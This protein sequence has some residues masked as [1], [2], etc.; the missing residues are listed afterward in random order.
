VQE[1]TI[2]IV[3]VPTSLSGG[4]YQLL[5]GGTRDDTHEK[6]PFTKGVRAPALVVLDPDLTTT[7]PEWVWLST[8]IRGVDHCVE[9]MC[10]L[11]S[12]PEAD[13]SAAEGL[14]LLVPGLLE[15]KH[16]HGDLKARLQCQMG[17]IQAM[18]AVRNGVPM[19]ASH[20]I[21]HQLGPLGMGHGETSCIL[22]PTVCKFNTS[23]NGERQKKVQDILWADEEVEK[24]LKTRGLSKEQADLGDM[25]DAIIRELGMP[26]T[27]KEKG[28]GREKLE[29]LA[30][31][32][33]GDFWIKTNPIP[34]DKESQVMEILEQVVG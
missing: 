18:E 24:V 34:I 12:N 10:S 33:L 11:K 23:V 6:F 16:N 22:L 1:V 4:E 3:C 26:R 20:A 32:S 31:N 2:P 7:T 15:T 19:G 29:K 13:A 27:L 25:L 8:G 14:K 30:K 21:G 17:V 9:T 5:A 28:I